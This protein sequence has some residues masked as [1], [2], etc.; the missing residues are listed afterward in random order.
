[1]QG[2]SPHALPGQG[3]PHLAVLVHETSAN[4]LDE[5][6]DPRAPAEPQ[7]HHQ[8]GEQQGVAAEHGGGEARQRGALP[9]GL[10]LI[11]LVSEL[12][13]QQMTS[14]VPAGWRLPGRFGGVA[15][16]KDSGVL[17]LTT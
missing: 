3:E 1:M 7:G 4:H 6:A 13:E 12:G 14:A 16:V 2:P 5:G 8:G 10:S 17:N 9:V 11:L 15:G